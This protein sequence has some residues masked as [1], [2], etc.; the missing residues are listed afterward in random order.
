MKLAI[1]VSTTA[2]RTAFGRLSS[3]SVRNNRHTPSVTDAKIRASRLRAPALSLTGYGRMLQ[4]PF[5]FYRGPAGIPSGGI[6]FKRTFL[7]QGKQGYVAGLH[8]D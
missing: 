5:A 1:A 8:S 7:E 6:P 2:A 4:S 3:R